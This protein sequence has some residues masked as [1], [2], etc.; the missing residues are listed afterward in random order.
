MRI[1]TNLSISQGL[2]LKSLW[3]YNRLK[4]TWSPQR[5]SAIF[6][7]TLKINGWIINSSI[8]S[9]EQSQ[10]QTK[11]K[12][13]NQ[14]KNLN[15]LQMI[16]KIKNLLQIRSQ[17]RGN[18]EMTSMKLRRTTLQSLNVLGMRSIGRSL[19]ANLQRPQISFLQQNLNPLHLRCNR[20]LSNRWLNPREIA[21]LT[22]HFN[23]S[24]QVLVQH[25]LKTR[26]QVNHL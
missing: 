4:K 11:A 12:I 15:S 26:L 24:L 18:L 16:I 2:S 7:L 9:W 19:V 20:L 21:T 8:F 25:L 1:G 13:V 14:M 23:S 22:K 6:S 3:S 10:T 5:N 17:G